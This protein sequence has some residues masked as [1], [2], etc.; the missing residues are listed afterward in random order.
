MIIGQGLQIE[1]IPSSL[2]T[3]APPA[4]N[5]LPGY[6][7]VLGYY[8]N[9]NTGP[10][11]LASLSEPSRT[12]EMDRRDKLA[13]RIT[14]LRIF[15]S[16]LD[17]TQLNSQTRNNLFSVSSMA[18]KNL[19]I[20]GTFDEDQDQLICY[21]KKVGD[22][23]FKPI[24]MNCTPDDN[25]Y[26][27][28]QGYNNARTTELDDGAYTYHAEILNRNEGV[29]YKLASLAREVTVDTVAPTYTAA[30]GPSVA[31]VGTRILFE[32]TQPS[33]PLGNLRVVPNVNCSVAGIVGQ[34]T[35]DKNRIEFSIVDSSRLV[36]ASNN[37][38][39]LFRLVLTDIY[40]N[41]AVARDFTVLILPAAM[42]PSVL[43]MLPALKLVTSGTTISQLQKKLVAQV[44]GLIID[45]LSSL[46]EFYASTTKLSIALALPIDPSNASPHPKNDFGFAYSWTYSCKINGV[47]NATCPT[48][49]NLSTYG[50]ATAPLTLEFYNFKYTG[51]SPAV[52][53]PDLEW[54]KTI[55]IK[56]V[57]RTTTNQSLKIVNVS[58]TNS[59]CFLRLEGV[60]KNT[61]TRFTSGTVPTHLSIKI[62]NP[63]S[64]VFEYRKTLPFTAI[65]FANNNATF[66]LCLGEG[67]LVDTTNP[68][69]AT[70]ATSAYRYKVLV[71]Q[72]ELEEYNN[73]T[74]SLELK[75]SHSQL[76]YFT[77][78]VP[79]ENTV[80]ASFDE[81]YHAPTSQW[82]ATYKV[83]NTANQ[84]Y[85][86]FKSRYGAVL[87]TLE[88]ITVGA[89]EN[90]TTDDGSLLV[91]VGAF[92]VELRNN[93]NDLD[94]S[95]SL[96]LRSLSA[97]VRRNDTPCQTTYGDAAYTSGKNIYHCE[98]RMH[99]LAP[100]QVATALVHA[101]RHTHSTAHAHVTCSAVTVG[102][103]PIDT[104]LNGTKNCDATLVSSPVAGNAGSY[105]Y[106]IAYL[107]GIHFHAGNMSPSAR[108][109][110]GRAANDL[111]YYNINSNRARRA[112]LQQPDQFDLND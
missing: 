16:S 32:F 100:W 26:R 19:R 43:N 94:K 77:G 87:N 13:K 12:I 6:V 37:I 111:L 65:T 54:S 50:A 18:L 80:P 15:A 33:E 44:E 92:F 107:A 108:L 14:Y 21:L 86:F 41:G 40:G 3:S 64:S 20:E 109:K 51:V 7:P 42:N 4:S 17:Y 53:I 28:G 62:S 58:T 23:S 56:P 61:D 29:R 24:Y 72:M 76:V 48:V 73:P 27:D 25:Y 30:N 104:A 1:A 90:S 70:I 36:S 93:G 110:A 82:L 96:I 103:D 49:I 79:F 102:S 55:T 99:G 5:I 68:T 22:A 34:S 78:A 112:A 63:S 47:V 89:N 9:G 84:A 98:N 52:S 8:L 46:T 101:A 71:S 38:T 69:N 85:T 11:P 74:I 57:L 45:D 88:A 83:N 106:S 39:C 59:T 97:I 105:T 75:A 91:N 67:S 10:D 60:L 31:Y 35:V 66:N 95:N 81:T 2:A